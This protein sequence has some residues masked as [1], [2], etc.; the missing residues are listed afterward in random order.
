L[1]PD[2]AAGRGKIINIASLMGCVREMQGIYSATKAA[3]INLTQ[4][5][6][7]ELASDHIQVNAIAP[8]L[9]KTKRTGNLGKDVLKKSRARLG[10]W[11]SR[12]I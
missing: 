3:V 2:A 4:T 12:R 11:A 1:F 9:V 10:E 8:G 7:M 5:L 6:A